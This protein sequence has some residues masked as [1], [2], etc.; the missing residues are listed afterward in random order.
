MV[1]DKSGYPHAALRAGLR[2]LGER[3]VNTGEARL[4]V[5]WT[6][7]AGTWRADAA[8]RYRRDGRPVIVVENGWL[9]PFGDRSFFQMALDGWNGGGRFPAGDGSRWQSWGMAPDAWRADGE[10]I[11]VLGQRGH[12]VDRRNAPPGWHETVRLETGRP[13]LR[14]GRNESRPLADD[15]AGAWAAVTW[16]SNAASRAILAGIPVF[17]AGPLMLADCAAPLADADLETPTMPDRLPVLERCAWAQ[18][19]ADEIATGAP[20]ARLLEAA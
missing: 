4:L 13:V 14:R 8:D 6:P 16:S 19:T 1:P 2:A 20:L 12:P 3:I 10:H 9:S 18:W 17:H 15:L 7:W 11:V 5:T